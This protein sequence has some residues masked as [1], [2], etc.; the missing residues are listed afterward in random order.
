MKIIRPTTV[1]DAMLTTSNVVE[2]DK[3]EYNPA[4]AYTTG[5]QIMVTDAGIHKIYE[6]L[7]ST[8]ADYPPTSALDWLEIDSTSRWAM[9]DGAVG[10]TTTN[11]DTIEVSITPG[12]IVNSLAFIG[13]NAASITVTVTDPVEGLIYSKTASLIS[14]NGVTE[15]YNYFFEGIS[16]KSDIVFTDLPNYGSAI[17]DVIIED[18][19]ATPSLG[20]MIIGT[21]KKLGDSKFG[22]RFGITD[23]ST[24][25]TDSFGRPVVVERAYAKRGEIDLWIPANDFDDVNVTLSGYRITPLVW[26]MTERFTTSII[27]GYWR[28]FVPVT[29]YPT[30]C[31][32]SIE[33]EGLTL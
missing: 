24:K 19:G 17:I 26:I 21:V 12:S 23:Y 20:Q 11:A 16:R 15:W 7:R 32:C 1:T 31:E 33:I 4:T 8:T 2:D 14:A 30:E 18:T 29:S 13:I 3:A 10:T 5:N 25:E 22:A 6:A 27:Y 9:F 28:S